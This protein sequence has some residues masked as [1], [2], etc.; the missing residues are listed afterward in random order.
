M[1]SKGL[2]L[3]SLGMTCWAC[4]SQ[5]EGVAE[6]GESVYIRFRHGYLT[7]SK[8]GIEGETIY[9]GEH[10]DGGGGVMDTQSM[11]RYTGMEA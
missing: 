9:E 2:K 5:W 10:E 7:V 1:E 8:P 6:D 4:P 3:K 11:L